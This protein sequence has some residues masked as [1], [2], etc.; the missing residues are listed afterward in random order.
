MDQVSWPRSSKKTWTVNEKIQLLELFKCNGKKWKKYAD[1]FPFRPD[2]DIKNQ[3]FSLIRKG[4]RC[5]CR[6]VGLSYLTSNLQKIKPNNLCAVMYMPLET[7]PK[8][9][10]TNNNRE[11]S[12][13]ELTMLDMILHFT[14]N[15]RTSELPD[16]SFD[17]I[18]NIKKYV[19]SLFE[20]K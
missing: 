3:L 16:F 14:K 15:E 11:Y 19:N 18:L 17:Y 12:F 9:E 10:N 13:T 6:L 5:L 8:F 2:I 7:N 4:L 1:S 20:L